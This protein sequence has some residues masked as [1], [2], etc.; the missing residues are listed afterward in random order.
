[1]NPELK[2]IEKLTE[3]NKKE[4]EKYNLEIVAKQKEVESRIT[5]I[6]ANEG[7][8]EQIKND[9][10]YIY[11]SINDLYN[12][13]YRLSSRLS[14]ELYTYAYNHQKGHLPPINSASKM[15]EALKILN[16]EDEYNYVKPTYYMASKNTIIANL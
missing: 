15:E 14:E 12:M 5:S 4:I 9:L 10:Q 13:N 1:M 16:L 8:I 6:T 7:N 2:K 11:K 3:D